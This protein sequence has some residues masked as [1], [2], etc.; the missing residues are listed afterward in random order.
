M[1]IGFFCT[2]PRVVAEKNPIPSPDYMGPR[3]GV[4]ESRRTERVEGA[5]R[6][7][8]WCGNEGYISI[9]QRGCFVGAER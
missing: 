6:R 2:D 7:C 1:N 3:C 4:C 8:A 9:T 5:K